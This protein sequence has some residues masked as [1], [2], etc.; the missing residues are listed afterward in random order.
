MPSGVD[1]NPR[2]GR[3]QRLDDINVTD[4]QM[5]FTIDT[6]GLYI[7]YKDERGALERG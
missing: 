6:G 5:L 7:D 3:R 1:F 4:G 2:R